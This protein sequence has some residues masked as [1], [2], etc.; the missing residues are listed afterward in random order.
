MCVKQA[1]RSYWSVFVNSASH[2]ST[3]PGQAAGQVPTIE[4]HQLTKS[5]DS[6]TCSRCQCFETS[7]EPAFL[8]GRT[9]SKGKSVNQRRG[10]SA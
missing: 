7:H 8:A 5:C 2:W 6:G 3:F 9:E 4:R 10:S 1:P